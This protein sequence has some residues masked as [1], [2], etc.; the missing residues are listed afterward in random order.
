MDFKSIKSFIENKFEE[1]KEDT[2]KY[3]QIKE[4]CQ[5]TLFQ[6]KDN[7]VIQEC[8]DLLTITTEYEFHNSLEK[9]IEK[10]DQTISK[11]RSIDLE[12]I[13]KDVMAK[14][15]PL[16]YFYKN[17][18]SYE[19]R[20]AAYLEYLDK[21]WRFKDGL[22]IEEY[23]EKLE[24]IPNYFGLPIRVKTFKKSTYSASIYCLCSHCG[25]PT[26]YT[27]AKGCKCRYKLN[28]YFP[29]DKK[30]VK[31]LERQHYPPKDQLDKDNKEDQEILKEIEEMERMGIAY[32]ISDHNHDGTLEYF[33]S[34]NSGMNNNQ[35]K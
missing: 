29:K 25:N 32:K 19:D 20:K 22:N 11:S 30:I 27:G 14:K 21:Y 4:N 23:K 24:S 12:Q 1:Y 16:M 31:T 28:I 3:Y 17:E 33:K 34:K 35:R 5:Q 26:T 13:H 18:H 2:N 9:I 15:I 7:G 8:M 10:L 6:Y